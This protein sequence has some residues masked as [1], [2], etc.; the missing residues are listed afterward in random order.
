LL[1]VSAAALIMLR[2]S[3]PAANRNGETVTDLESNGENVSRDFS[4]NVE[5]YL[6]QTK[7]PAWSRA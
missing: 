7:C 4:R 2:R 6:V 3:N 1:H 5:N